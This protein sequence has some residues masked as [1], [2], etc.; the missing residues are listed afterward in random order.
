MDNPKSWWLKKTKDLFSLTLHVYLGLAE[1]STPWLF[2]PEIRLIEHLTPDVSP[3]ARAEVKW[4]C[5]A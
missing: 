3:T 4:T 5:L 1:S 2:S